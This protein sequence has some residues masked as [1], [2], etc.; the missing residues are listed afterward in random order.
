MPRPKQLRLFALLWFL[1]SAAV[2]A[3]GFY[4]A[5]FIAPVEAT[6]GNVYRIFYWHVPTN[7][8]AFIFPYVNLAGALWLLVVRNRR[9][10]QALMADA[11]ALAGA[12]ITVV[13]SSLGLITG[14]LWARPVWG[15]WWTWD[16]RLTT[17][18]LLWVLYVAYLLLRRFSSTGQT[19]VLA[20]ILSIFAAIDVPISYMSIV[21]WRTQHPSPVIRGE[22]SLDPSMWPALLWNFAGWGM[23]GILLLGFRYTLERRR[24]LAA[25]DEALN[26]IDAPI[27]PPRS[28]H[29]L[30]QELA[31]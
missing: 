8:C 5:I 4:L 17:A 12:E 31:Q 24:Q 13:Y 23:W 19:A 7:I 29:P 11:L 28:A 1:A 15:I 9:P 10:D 30:S 3:Y 27:G 26:A 25:E 6:M 21:W 20:A 22:G 2:L 14:M 16:A 18:L